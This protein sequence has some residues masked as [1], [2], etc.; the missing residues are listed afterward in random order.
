MIRRLSMKN[1]SKLKKIKANNSS[2]RAKVSGDWLYLSKQ[3]LSVRDLYQAIPDTNNC[4]IWEEA[5]ILE[6]SIG[7]KSS[8]DIE[9]YISLSLDSD[10]SEALDAAQL[11]SLGDEI[12]DN[13]LQ[14]YDTKSLFYVSFNPENY[15]LAKAV[16]EAI[17][18]NIGG[19]FC[20]DTEDFMPQIK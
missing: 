12:G 16:M 8:I 9:A 20:A 4:E 18:K 1:K 17:V 5:G 6:I 10:T 19:L 2:T 14:A 11:P 3:I 15:E 13:F 7:E